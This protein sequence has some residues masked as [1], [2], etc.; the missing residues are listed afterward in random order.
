M[1][2]HPTAGLVY[3]IFR[4]KTTL[5]VRLCREERFVDLADIRLRHGLGILIEQTLD[6]KRRIG[7][8]IDIVAADVI[9]RKIRRDFECTHKCADTLHNLVGTLLLG[10]RRINA[11]GI[12]NL[13]VAVDAGVLVILHHL[14]QQHRVG[15]AVG[16]VIRAAE[17]IY[18]C[19]QQR[20][21]CLPGWA[22]D[23]H[24]T[25]K[26]P[27]LAGKAG[28]GKFSHLGLAISLSL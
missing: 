5:F 12:C 26:I 28:C 13:A 22:Q 8:E 17:R 15:H 6:L 19:P 1:E 23:R 7:Q 14:R 10:K 3:G 16:D 18:P 27:G 20:F 24:F 9:G 21:S 4:M 2:Y 11:E 25:G